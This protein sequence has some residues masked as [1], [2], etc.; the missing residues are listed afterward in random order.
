MESLQKNAEL[1]EHHLQ[2]LMKQG[3][4]YKKD[5]GV[6]LKKLKAVG[7]IPKYAI[8]V[9]T[10]VGGIY[11]RSP[12]ETV[13]SIQEQVFPTEHIIKMADF[14]L[15]T[16]FLN[17]T[18]NYTSKYQALPLGLNLHLRTK[19]GPSTK[20]APS[21]FFTFFKL[22]KWYQVVR[23]IYPDK[24]QV[25]DHHLNCDGKGLIYLLSYTVCSLQYVV[26]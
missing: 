26:L 21:V 19:S 17:S 25:Q 7:E 1:F 10:Y 9:K 22:C 12:S 2:P 5:T 8:F 20:T 6:F 24:T 18:L 11:S 15:K 14:V 16:T 23:S 3:E 13:R 4:S